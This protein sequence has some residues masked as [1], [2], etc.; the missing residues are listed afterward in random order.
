MERAHQ[1]HSVL[2]D[3]GNTETKYIE[4]TFDIGSLKID[5]LLLLLHF[6]HAAQYLKLDNETVN[7][8]CKMIFNNRK[9]IT[10]KD[11]ISCATIFFV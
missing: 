4:I 9:K 8:K 2:T 10:F 3:V 7:I 6:G 11:F 1:T 5:L